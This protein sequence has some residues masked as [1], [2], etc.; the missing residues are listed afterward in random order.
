MGGGSILGVALAPRLG[1]EVTLRLRQVRETLAA[2]AR[3]YP[4]GGP[5]IPGAGTGA[6][7]ACARKVGQAS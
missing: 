7:R 6:W 1:R 5:E 3:Q 2:W 4:E